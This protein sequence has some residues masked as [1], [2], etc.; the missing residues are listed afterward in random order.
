MRVELPGVESSRDISVGLLA[1]AQQLCLGVPGK[2]RLEL[3]LPFPVVDQGVSTTWDRVKHRLEIVL[4]V[5]QP[6][7]LGA[8]AVLPEEGGSGSSS[9]EGCL[10]SNAG[11]G[12]SVKAQPAPSTVPATHPD[13]PLSVTDAR[14]LAAGSSAACGRASRPA[15]SDQR[16]PGGSAL[17]AGPQQ[18]AAADEENAAPGLGGTYGASSQSAQGGGALGPRAVS[19]STHAP[20]LTCSLVDD[21]D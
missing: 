6:P 16:L 2:Y 14:A 20:H 12:G 10:G 8:G 19:S 18:R 9:E 5:V 21:L 13:T 17:L 3:Q 1:Q 11:A 15:E 4:P 7:L